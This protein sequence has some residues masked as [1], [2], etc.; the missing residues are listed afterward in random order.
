MTT[1]EPGD[2]KIKEETPK[3]FLRHR[4]G[5][6][7]GCLRCKM[8][9]E[10]MGEKQAYNCPGKPCGCLD[11]AYCD[12]CGPPDGEVADWF[13]PLGTKLAP[14]EVMLN[15]GRLMTVD[16]GMVVSINPPKHVQLVVL[17][18]DG[19]YRYYPMDKHPGGWRID[20]TD[21]TLIIGKG[22][23]RIIIPLETIDY[24]SPEEY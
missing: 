24:F 14:D 17:R 16:D 8:T 13:N 21:R 7:G 18:G 12:R 19:T 5:R 6:L 9:D 11:E 4:L 20:P 1:N 23:G 22:M 3:P 2:P 10:E 15:P